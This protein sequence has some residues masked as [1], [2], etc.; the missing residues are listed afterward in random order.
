MDGRLSW[1]VTDPASSSRGRVERW[2][3]STSS[4]WRAFPLA[5]F[6][7]FRVSRLF[8]E[9]PL[10]ISTQELCSSVLLGSSSAY[11]WK[12]FLTLAFCSITKLNATIKVGSF[13]NSKPLARSPWPLPTLIPT[14]T[15][16]LPCIRDLP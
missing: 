16:L 15:F 11:L 5:L 2:S 6:F 8:L 14:F 1:E 4:D 3:V 7:S 12:L 10:E 13:K 9:V